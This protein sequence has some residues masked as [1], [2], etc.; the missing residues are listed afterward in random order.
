LRS[1]APEPEPAFSP[2]ALLFLFIA[3]VAGAV[4]LWSIADAPP[5]SETRGQTGGSSP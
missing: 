2:L 5:N 4:L 1:G 3:V